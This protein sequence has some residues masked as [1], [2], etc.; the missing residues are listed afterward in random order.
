MSSILMLITTN[1]LKG[2]F[3]E[4]GAQNWAISNGLKCFHCPTNSTLGKGMDA[5]FINEDTGQFIV[6]ESKW[7]SSNHNVGI[8][9]LSKT[10]SGKQLSDDWMFK[11]EELGNNAMNRTTGLTPVQ[12]SELLA[13]RE[14]GKISTQLVVVKPK[15]GGAGITQKLT[16]D[17]K[18]GANGSEKLGDIV[19]IE[20]PINL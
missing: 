14:A 11:G 3:V 5:I 13:A 16:D 7:I 18:F 6:S 10:N 19:I 15:H 12:R 1:E 2:E 8:G 20:V 4:R 17:P 9:S